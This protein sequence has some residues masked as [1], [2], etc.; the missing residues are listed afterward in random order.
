M[1]L[2]FSR[3][4][5]EKFSN[6]KFNENRPTGNPVVPFGLKDGQ[7]DMTKLTAAFQNFAK[8]PKII[9]VLR[10]KIREVNIRSIERAH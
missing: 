2:E 5:F 6:I 9:G 4:I 3:Q 1:N 8:A 10:G 7:P